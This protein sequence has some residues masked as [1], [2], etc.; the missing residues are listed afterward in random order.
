MGQT[1]RL[2]WRVWVRGVGFSAVVV[3]NLDGVGVPRGASFSLRLITKGRAKSGYNFSLR[4]LTK[5]RA[6]NHKRAGG[7]LAVCGYLKKPILVCGYLQT[8]ARKTGSGDKTAFIMRAYLQT[9]LL[10]ILSGYSQEAVAVKKF[11]AMMTPPR[12]EYE[13]RNVIKIK[14]LRRR[15]SKMAMPRREGERFCE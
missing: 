1:R 9:R 14:M 6:V 3:G 4:V 7:K 2:R 15:T 12:K 5:G 8:G 10:A 11:E 13:T